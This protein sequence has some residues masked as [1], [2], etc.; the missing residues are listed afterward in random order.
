VAVPSKAYVCA[1]CFAGIEGSNPAA[2]L[3]IRLLCLLCVVQ[4]APSAT[5]CSFVQRS[6]TVCVCV[7]VCA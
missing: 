4:V 1:C 5:C 2:G 6:L 7:S 3:Y